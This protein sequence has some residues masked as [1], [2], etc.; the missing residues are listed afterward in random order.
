MRFVWL[1]GRLFSG[2]NQLIKRISQTQNEF[3][4]HRKPHINLKMN[5]RSK[6]PNSW[7]EHI[8]S[9]FHNIAQAIHWRPRINLIVEQLVSCSTVCRVCASV[10]MC[11]CI[12]VY[13]CG[14]LWLFIVLLVIWL[15]LFRENGKKPEP[16]FSINSITWRFRRLNG[17]TTK[18]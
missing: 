3:R 2:G 16:N 5:E 8:L 18:S 7:N 9:S 15:H 13:V 4:I 6:D 10:G 1:K 17:H 12:C 14:V 11:V